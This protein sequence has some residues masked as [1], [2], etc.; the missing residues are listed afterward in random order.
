MYTNNK[1]IH[2][3]VTK[4]RKY[5]KHKNKR[6]HKAHRMFKYTQTKQHMGQYV[7]NNA[8]LSSKNNGTANIRC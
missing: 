2:W 7:N 1:S 6:E 3:T 4:T 5:I 8:H